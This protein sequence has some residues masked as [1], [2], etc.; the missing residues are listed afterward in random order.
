M[1]R[2]P[3]FRFIQK[4]DLG[5]APKWIDGLLDAF[6]ETTQFLLDAFNGNIAVNNLSVQTISLDITAPFTSTVVAK[7]KSD[8]V[9]TVLIAQVLD[10]NGNPL[11]V[12]SGVSWHEDGS[13]VVID[14]IF[15][16]TSSVAY[17]VTITVLYQ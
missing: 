17:N 2:K 7:T 16:L 5:D 10:T 4:N 11:G 1:L 9:Y 3:D 6:N 8:K 14:D 15:G 12:A 13:T